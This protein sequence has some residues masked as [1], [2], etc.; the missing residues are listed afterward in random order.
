MNNKIR[1]I[2]DIKS[3]SSFVVAELSGNH[4]GSLSIAKKIILKSKKNG[5]D[6]V[7]LQTF[8]LDSMTLNSNK[9]FFRIK[10]KKW[11]KLNL[12]KLY[13]KS[14]TPLKWHKEIFKYSKKIDLICFSTP[15]DVIS[16]NFLES[17]NCPIYKISSFEITDLN[18]IK[19]I[20]KTK[21]PVILSTGMASLNEIEEAIRVLKKN[22]SKKICLLH[23]ISE[24]PSDFKNSNLQNI[25]ILKKKFKLPV[26]LSDHSI[27]NKVSISSY[28]LGARVFEKHVRLNKKQ[29]SIDDFFSIIPEDIKILKDELKLI[30]KFKNNHI[31]SRNVN[32]LK[33]RVYRRSIFSTDLI[34][35]GE[36]V[37]RNNTKIVRPNYGLQPKMYNKIL[38]KKVTKNIF[39]FEPIKMKYLK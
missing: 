26:G 16:L 29:K 28:F 36:A 31:F 10:N 24:Y 21:K 34:K 39:P 18:L 27:D 38:G 19:A 17:L 22:G 5:A 37:T 4:A 35:K 3:K 12:Y 6:A 11:D 20:A 2:F 30:E 14:Q 25:K 9:K 7:K 15:F 8:D 1:N 23:C 33:N 13:K 32:E